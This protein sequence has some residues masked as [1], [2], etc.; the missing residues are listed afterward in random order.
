MLWGSLKGGHVGVGMWADVQDKLY[1]IDKGPAVQDTIFQ[2][3]MILQHPIKLPP[4]MKDDAEFRQYALPPPREIAL[5][6]GPGYL[7][8]LVAT[9]SLRHHSSGGFLICQLSRPG[10]DRLD[11]GLK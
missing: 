6:E 10:E 9:V 11:P 2:R 5:L 1:S 3:L 8:R 7:G 4:E